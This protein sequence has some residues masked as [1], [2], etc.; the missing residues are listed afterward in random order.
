MNALEITL[1]SPGD[2]PRTRSL[3]CAEPVWIG[4][5]PSCQVVLDSELV[6]RRHACIEAG[7]RDLS[8][9]DCS[10]NGTRV[11]GVLLQRARRSTGPV[12]VL[13]IGPYQLEVRLRPSALA[14]P[15]AAPQ[16]NASVALRRRDSAPL[17]RSTRPRTPLARGDRCRAHSARRI[18]ALQDI[19]ESFSSELPDAQAR[20]NLVRELTDEAL[21]LGPLEQLLADPT[22]SEIMVVDPRHDLR[23]ARRAARARRPRAS[24]TTKRVRV[25]DRAHRHAARPPHRRVERRW[26]TRAC[27]TAR[28]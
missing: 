27:P 3:A 25:G 12:T 5:D 24:P 15:L 4:R 18:A 14:A 11:D 13:E 26:S 8:V 20:S 10:A 23:G 19:C 28:A 17:A 2:A 7:A 1:R 6:S 9:R 16:T 22:V 21:G